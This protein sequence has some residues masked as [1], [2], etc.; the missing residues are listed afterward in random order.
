MTGPRNR[1]NWMRELDL[2]NPNIS[3]W[4]SSPIASENY[5]IDELQD[6]H[7]VSTKEHQIF[8]PS[9]AHTKIRVH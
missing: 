6:L 1:Q 5:M 2:K 3:P 7:K 8:F 4:H 9:N